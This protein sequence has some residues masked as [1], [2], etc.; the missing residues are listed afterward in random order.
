MKRKSHQK[1]RQ[2]KPKPDLSCNVGKST[3]SDW[4]SIFVIFV[5]TI[6]F[7]RVCSTWFFK[8]EESTKNTSFHLSSEKMLNLLPLQKKNSQK[9]TILIPKNNIPN[10]DTLLQKHY[11][12]SKLD[13]SNSLK[14]LFLVERNSHL[15]N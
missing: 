12:S 8:T 4:P 1:Q 7:G 10:G 6:Q 3:N 2:H 15:M 13:L 5:L 11:C 9:N 14:I